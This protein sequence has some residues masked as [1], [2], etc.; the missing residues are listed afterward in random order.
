MSDRPER[1]SVSPVY[2]DYALGGTGAAKID[3]VLAA[4]H[5]RVV[6]SLREQ[7]ATARANALEEAADVVETALGEEW[8]YSAVVDDLHSR[9]LRALREEP[10]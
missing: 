2:V 5:D 4:D 9:A 6:A 8:P 10:R 1:Y 7:L 3:V